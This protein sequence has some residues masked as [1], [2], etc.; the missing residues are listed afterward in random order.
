MAAGTVVTDTAGALDTA[1]TIIGF[2]A[3]I[4]SLVLA[5]G[6]I[7]LSF[8]FYKMS[9]EASKET[10]KAAKDIQ[11]SVE[12]LE[13]IFDKLY[14]DTFS[15]MRDTVTD[16][17]QHIWKKPHTGSS[18]DIINNEEKINNLKNSISQEI[19]CIVDE[20][21]KSNGDNETKIKE[22]EEMIKKALDSGIQKTIRSQAVPT[23]VM[24]RRALNLIRRYG[25][26]R[27]EHLLRR[28]NTMFS[29]DHSFNDN[30]FMP[31]LFNL[32]EN[33]L[34][35]WDGPSGRISSDDYLVYIGDGE[36][37]KEISE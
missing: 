12:R 36:K 33:G 25:K 28:M 22:L 9:N 30:E 19:I 15:M 17:R 13:K 14:S 32:R 26:I 31:A 29:E 34:I 6:A 27:V 5:V 10:T 37:N 2:I 35:T 4:A 3:T 18:D 21:L 8:V 11:A 16:M 7:W 23:T 20:K 1:I 24:R